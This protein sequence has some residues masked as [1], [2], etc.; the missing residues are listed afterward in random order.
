M[1]LDWR[2]YSLADLKDWN[3]R[4]AR[5]AVLAKYG[6]QVDWKA[7]STQQ[8][9][10]LQA[11]LRQIRAPAAQRRRRP[12]CPRISRP[13]ST[14]TRS[15]SRPTRTERT[16]Q[17]LDDSILPPSG[18]ARAARPCPPRAAPSARRR[19][20][21]PASR[22]RSGPRRRQRAASDARRRRAPAPARAVVS[23]P[24]PARAVVSAPPPPAHVAAPPSAPRAP[25]RPRCVRPPPRW[26]RPSLARRA[27][28]RRDHAAGRRARRRQARAHGGSRGRARGSSASGR[29]RSQAEPLR[30]N[31]HEAIGPAEGP[32]LRDRGD[33]GGRGDGDTDGDAPEGERALAASAPAESAPPR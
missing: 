29:P 20:R 25:D 19:P 26:S 4:C 16:A 28:P 24:P 17:S 32:R 31:A 9:D 27:R 8:L 7:Y 6:L 33:R 3:G 23:A 11:F 15:S 22:A 1:Q 12:S 21:A 13:A 30:G 18:A 5:A 10:D 14:R 2:T